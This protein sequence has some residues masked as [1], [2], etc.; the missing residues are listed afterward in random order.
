MTVLSEPV[1]V[2]IKGDVVHATIERRALLNAIDAEVIDGLGAAVAAAHDARAKVLVLR[3]A[4]GTFC[5]GADLRY[6]RSL[7]D[8]QPALVAFMASIGEVLTALERAPFT[9]VAVVEGHAV[10]GG[11]ELLLACDVVLASDD[12]RIGDYHAV[13]GLAPAAGSSVRLARSLP[14]AV[15]HHLLLSGRILDGVEAARHGLV[16][17]AVPR[18]QLD[19]AA[20]EAITELSS[21]SHAAIAATKAMLHAGRA[22]SYDTALAGELDAFARLAA[23]SHDLREGLTA[24]AEKRRPV[25]GATAALSPL[26]PIENETLDVDH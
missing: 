19:R 15:A 2:S 23:D 1:A 20:V 9:V 13:W 7:L 3:G 25:F 6:V 17:Q 21:R 18:D 16:T 8:D 5:A 26:T 24:F 22:G 14:R 10:A 4:G 11:F 12:A